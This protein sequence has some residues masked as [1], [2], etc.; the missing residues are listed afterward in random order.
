MQLTREVITVMAGC[1]LQCMRPVVPTCSLIRL[2]E[3]TSAIW[4][5]LAVSVR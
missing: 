5:V 3:I 2:A 4:R 1:V